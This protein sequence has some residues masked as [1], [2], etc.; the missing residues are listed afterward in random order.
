MEQHL[1]TWNYLIAIYLFT[2]GLSS[3]AGMIA[4]VTEILNNT[5]DRIKRISAYLA[6]FPVML[7]LLMLV[8]DLHRPWNFFQVLIHY[9]VTSVMSWGAFFLLVFPIFALIFTAMVYFNYQGA[10][11][12]LFAW[13]ELVLGL[14][15]GIY[16]GLLLAAI[17]NNPVWS[18]PLIAFLFFVSA[19]STGICMI[20][21]GGKVWDQTETFIRKIMPA[22]LQPEKWLPEQISLNFD[23]N[24][25]RRLIGIDAV[26]II[27]ELMVISTL[28]ISYM[29]RPTGDIALGAIIT[30]GYYLT[31]WIGVVLLGLTLPLVLGILE[32]RDRFSDNM[33]LIVSIAEPILV[34]TGGFILRWV[35]VYGGQLV[36]P[37]LTFYS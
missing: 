17:Y 37:I 13:L 21:L 3:G 11:R 6:P 25:I 32:L 8:A 15:I 27:I 28:I 30:G 1:F 2:A 31:F 20:I 7:G 24:I 4:G 10:L 5:S 29:L 35:V 9:H 22:K 18:N 19:I 23:H 16:A 26:I 36:Y 14:A 34:L 33:N 12:K